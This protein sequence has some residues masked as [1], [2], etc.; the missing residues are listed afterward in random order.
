MPQ[1][2]VW[3]LDAHLRVNVGPSRRNWRA[4]VQSS[5]AVMS[6]RDEQLFA[7]CSVNVA[8]PAQLSPQES[9]TVRSGITGV[10]SA[11]VQDATAASDREERQNGKAE[12][13][14]HP[15]AHGQS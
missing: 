4:P 11:G 5:V 13:V 1:E 10:V 12:R 14:S 7:N 15:S 3:L 9:N 8:L 2:R 6:F